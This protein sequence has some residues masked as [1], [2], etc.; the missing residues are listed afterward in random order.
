MSPCRLIILSGFLEKFFSIAS[1]I[2][3]E[4]VLCSLLVK[5]LFPPTSLITFAISS[6]AVAT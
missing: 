6:S 2:L 4:P 3:S 1:K 5:I